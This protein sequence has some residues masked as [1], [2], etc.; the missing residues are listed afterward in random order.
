MRKFSKS[1]IT[2]L[3][4]FF[5][6]IIGTIAWSAGIFPYQLQTT[7]DPVDNRCY[8]YDA[9]TQ[10]GTWSVCGAGG[11]SGTMNTTKE[12]GVQ[13]GDAD[14][15]ILDFLGADFNLNE[16]PNTEINIEIEDSGISHD[17]VA[18]VST[19]DHHARTAN[20]DD[21]DDVDTT[22]VQNRSHIMWSVPNGQ[23]EIT[24]PEAEKIIIDAEAGETIAVGDVVY[25]S[26]ETGGTPIVSIADKDTPSKMPAIGIALEGGSVTDDI[27]VI[28]YGHLN[29]TDTSSFSVGDD[30][31]VGST[32]AITNV[33]PI[34]TSEIQKIAQVM[35]AD[36][37]GHL[38]V[39]G[40]GR[41]NDIPNIPSSQFWVGDGNGVPQA[42]SMGG[43]ASMDNTG[44]V[45]VTLSASDIAIALGTGSPT[46][47]QIQEYFDNTGS[48]GFF[49]GGALSDGGAGTLDVAAGEGFIRTTNDDNA[50][51]QSFKW[52][53]S[54]GIAVSDDTT[55]YVYVDDAGAITLST[56]EFLETP[57]NILIGVVTDEGGAIESVFNLGVRLEESIGAAGRFMR[58]VHGIVKNQRVGGLVFG[59][60]GDANRDVTL[61]AGQLEWGRT[62]YT[63][64]SFDTSG[65][66]TFTTYSAGGQEA[67]TASQWPNEQY[68]NAGT[69]TT[70]TNNRWAVLWFYIEPDDHVVMVYGRDQYITQGQAE[71]EEPPSSSLPSRITETGVLN[72]RY[73][74]QKSANTSSIE[75]VDPSFGSAS[76]T[77]HGNLAG[78]TDDDHTQ[79]LLADGSRALA[80]AWDMGSQSLTNVNIDSGIITGITDLAV[81]DGGTGASTLNDLITLTTHTTGNYAAGDAEAGAC[82][83]GDTATAFFSSGTIEHERGGLEADIN[84]YDGLIG[85]TGGATFNQTGSTTEIIIFDGAGA[86]TSASLSNDITMTNAG[87]V[88]I[89]ANS[90]ALT[91]DTTGNYVS[92]ATANQ[93]LLL[94][95]TE[96][97][98]LGLIDC[99]ASEI[100]ARDG[101]D[102]Q[103]ECTAAGAGDITDIFDCASGDCNEVT[104]ETGDFL[105]FD[106]D[107]TLRFGNADEYTIDYNNGT[108]DVLQFSTAEVESVTTESGMYTYSVD[109]GN[110]GMTA[111]QEVFEI[112]K[113]GAND[114]D[115]NFVELWAIDEDGDMSNIGTATTTGLIISGVGFDGIGAVDL[116]YGSV[117]ITDHT[118]TTD[119][120]GDTEIVLPNDSIGPAEID[121]TTGAYDFSGV[122]SFALPH[123]A[124]PT[125]DATAETALDTTITDHQPLWQYFDGGENMTIIAI[126]TAQL[127]AVDNEIIKY[128]AGTDKFVLE[129]DV[130]GGGS[131]EMDFD[132]HSAKITGSFVTDG[133]AT[134]GAQIDAG[135]GN[136]RLLFDDTVDEAAVWQIR[137]SPNC[138]GL[139]TAKIQYSMT[140]ATADDVK[141]EIGIMAI[142]DGDAVDV[143][144][145]SF[146][147]LNT[148]TATVPGTAGYLDEIS[149]TLTN[150]DS[151]AAEDAL[152]VYLSTDSDDAGDDDAT[153]DREVINLKLICD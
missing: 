137:T 114:D 71:E 120:T 20:L 130:G 135:D 14:I 5:V 61:T 149:I 52:S 127:P 66:D 51:L 113:G 65:A 145:P 80:G 105:R 2:Q 62:S 1:L 119:S 152:W 53:A 74:F 79:Y 106:D 42:V 116:D 73:I 72:A 98:N 9:A 37:N 63:I 58:G 6:F 13:V 29:T 27:E 144:T 129:A 143:G 67:A 153:G 28:T 107:V 68:D 4:I 125:T 101:G 16:S 121:S 36:V 151:F 131:P 19:S 117:D 35:I 126:D 78:L 92:S 76:V 17:S 111:D 55:Q 11:G 7:N 139:A 136:W 87:V 115:G 102:T 31:Y 124:A 133:D 84:A 39:F 50:E 48:S 99:A 83:T 85:I 23:W 89:S 25:L 95:G 15:E 38:F 60:S 21:L 33:K 109:S 69:L 47:D 12:N 104:V 30:I 147:T 150:D 86:P 77:D 59:Q 110:S 134:Q 100:L 123:D 41:S 8:T 81:A 70:M 97:A 96:G 24:S 132:V 34:G 118:F 54:A 3:C 32:G 18:D 122:T 94:T 10:Q 142:S 112:G 64:S 108:E 44:S 40:A 43:Q 138:S 75:T 128:D 148:G 88:T 140:S 46:V 91:T 90:V 93:G 82:L 103:W 146:D 57:D 141:F 22:G 45:T 56:N 49:T 26:G